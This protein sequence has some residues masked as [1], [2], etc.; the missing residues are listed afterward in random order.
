[1]VLEL[2]HDGED[3]VR[4]IALRLPSDG[5][6]VE[7]GVAKLHLCAIPPAA[8]EEI[9]E[10]GRPLGEVL[11]RHNVLRRIEPTGFWRFLRSAALRDRVGRPVE[12]AYGR[13]GVIY[14]DGEPA[15]ELLEVV[16]DPDRPDPIRN[17]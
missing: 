17:A 4:E 10:R 3:Y 5:R 14:C 13:T 12:V 8:R 1:E 6:V 2:R 16:I 15:I 7:Y 11:I 9:L